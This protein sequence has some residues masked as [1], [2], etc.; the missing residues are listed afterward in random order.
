MTEGKSF[1]I[2][3]KKLN[4]Q[5]DTIMVVTV[6]DQDNQPN[7]EELDCLAQQVADVTKHLGYRCGV[8]V[9]PYWI[10]VENI[11]SSAIDNRVV[12]IIKGN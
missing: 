7:Q 12:Q 6:G 3:I 10:N 1:E 8:M 11:P 9:L 5:D 4:P 2:Q